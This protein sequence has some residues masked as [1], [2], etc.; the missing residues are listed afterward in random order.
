MAC[1]L[2]SKSIARNNLDSRVTS[3]A[4]MPS[5]ERT[6][7]FYDL[8]HI[9]FRYVVL[10]LGCLV[11]GSY[12]RSHLFSGSQP[13]RA[14]DSHFLRVSAPNHWETKQ[15]ENETFISNLLPG[16]T[17]DEVIAALGQPQFRDTYNSGVDMLYYRTHEEH[18][19]MFTTRD[20]TTPL[21]FVD[22]KLTSH[23]RLA[24]GPAFDRKSRNGADHW[25]S[26][27]TEDSQVIESLNPG[28]ARADVVA[29]M[30]APDF[31]DIVNAEFEVLSWRTH[32]V[33]SDGYTARNETTPL[34]FRNGTLVA[35]GWAPA[36]NNIDNDINVR[37]KTN[38]QV[39]QAIEQV[40]QDVQQQTRDGSD[41]QQT[42]V[43]VQQ[44]IEKALQRA[45]N[46]QAP[47][48][49][50]PPA[51]VAAPNSPSNPQSPGDDS[52]TGSY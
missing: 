7:L 29:R 21:V 47:A 37:V 20:E 33:S 41:P 34:V 25:Q 52:A 13:D 5:T 49:V 43:I 18:M 30:G 50:A 1:E 2:L 48:P 9:R 28:A 11:G 10:V 22:G 27:Q 19:D 36:N 26:R 51:P 15:K 32:S 31:D 45:I 14:T 38:V 24:H 42:G 23:D 17:P 3:T 8:T 12:L 16:T 44:A 35:V 4:N 6:G 46:D 39:K 40:I